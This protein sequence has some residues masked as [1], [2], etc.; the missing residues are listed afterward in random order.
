MRHLKDRPLCLLNSRCAGCSWR[1]FTDRN[2]LLCQSISFIRPILLAPGLYKL[3]LSAGGKNAAGK[4]AIRSTLQPALRSRIDETCIWYSREQ[5]DFMEELHSFWYHIFGYFP[6]N[7]EPSNKNFNKSY[8]RLVP[9]LGRAFATPSLPYI[10][11]SSTRRFSSLLMKRCILIRS[12]VG[13]TRRIGCR[14]L[15]KLVTACVHFA[16]LDLSARRI[17][18]TTLRMSFEIPYRSERSSLATLQR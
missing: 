15:E 12:G 14:V 11:S 1:D 13:L 18:N 10:A 4:S 9:H 7:S 8:V 2:T 5:T 3:I 17:L 16:K 6:F